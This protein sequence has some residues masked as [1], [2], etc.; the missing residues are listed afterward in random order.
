MISLHQQAHNTQVPW[1]PNP[2]QCILLIRHAKRH[3]FYTIKVSAKIT[4]HEKV[5][6]LRQQFILDQT[7]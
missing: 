6:K 5:G 2:K 3:I 7:V 1:A 4:L